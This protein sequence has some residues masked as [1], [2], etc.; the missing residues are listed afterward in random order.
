MSL[1]ARFL[2]AWLALALPARAVAGDGPDQVVEPGPGAPRGVL[3]EWKTPEGRPYW[4][5]LPKKPSQSH[6]PNL[7]LML[8]GTGLDHRWSF[9]NYP[10]ATGQ[11]RGDDVVVS[12]DGLTPQDGGTFNFVQGKADGDQVKG[13]IQSLRKRL[14]LGKVYLYGH[15]QGA[16]FCYWFAGEYP[17]LVDG[18]VAHAGNVLDVAHGK[19]AKEKVAIGILHGAADAVVPVEC[20]Y[21]T[22]RIYR[23]QGYRNVKLY[24]V[25]GLNANSGHWPLPAQASEMFDWLDRVTIADAPTSLAAALGAL[26]EPEPDLAAVADSVA[27]A[28]A[29]LKKASAGDRA[30]HERAATLLQSLLADAARAHAAALALDASFRDPKLPFGA[31]VGHFRAAE[32]ALATVPEWQ[33][34]AKAVRAAATKHNKA[35]EAALKATVAPSKKTLDQVRRALEEAYLADNAD[36]LRAAARRLGQDPPKGVKP[37]EIAALTDALDRGTAAIAEGRAAARAAEKPVIEAFRAAHPELF[38]AA[39]GAEDE[40]G[41]G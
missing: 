9:F 13:L 31:W 5:R 23:E 11:F 29:L 20:A 6:P 26:A 35:A 39:R 3:L 14:T 12:P 18:I 25:E 40:P 30:E 38:E 2:V 16:F 10:I 15:S 22:E 24:V 7:V 33:A 37:E 21:R 32:T 34:T 4:Y 27:R 41:G 1:P 19:L 36:E 17:E 28:T 8:H